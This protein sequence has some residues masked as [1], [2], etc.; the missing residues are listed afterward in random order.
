VGTAGANTI[1][2]N[3]VSGGNAENG[4]GVGLCASYIQTTG[5]GTTDPDAF[6]T[7]T[8]AHARA[9]SLQIN[10]S[11]SNNII[12]V[13]SA[14]TG[15]LFNGTGV[16]TLSLPSGIQDGD[17]LV[18]IGVNDNPGVPATPGALNGRGWNT[19]TNANGVTQI[20]G[21][22]TSGTLMAGTSNDVRGNLGGLGFRISYQNYTPGTGTPQTQISGLTAG[23]GTIPTCHMLIAFRNA[24]YGNNTRV[25]DNGTNPTYGP[26]DP[27]PLPTNSLDSLVLAIGMVDNIKIS[28]VSTV[29]APTNYTMLAEPQSYG[30]QNNGSIIMTAN[31]NNMTVT[32]D[33]PGNFGGNGGNIWVSQTII[34]SG[35]ST[36]GT[37]DNPGFY[38]GGGASMA[39]D[40]VGAGMTGGQGSVRLIWGTG[41]R[42]PSSNQINKSLFD[43]VP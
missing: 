9:Y 6:L 19:Q 16:S 35:P 17:L 11:G 26:P 22:T 30:V 20:T 10:K 40:T 23:T 32:T 12:V 39:D 38:G 7:G 14:V 29:T 33:D 43:S 4:Q 24:T 25:W 3:E 34:I 21:T 1:A 37:R 31:R 41:R 18:Y 2:I 5:I 15:T 36:T 13:G 28:N 42:Y 8:A 27:P